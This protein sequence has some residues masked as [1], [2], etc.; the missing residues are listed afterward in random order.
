M[1]TLA[2][3]RANRKQQNFYNRLGPRHLAPL[4]EVLK[5]LVPREPKSKAVPFQWKYQ[6]LR[7]LLME[8]GELVSAEEAERRAL[9]LENPAFPG[10]SRTTSTMYAAVQLIMPG[11]TAPAHRHTASALRFML[12]G[13]GAFTVVGGERTT[14]HRGDFVITPAWAFHDHGNSGSEP[15][16]WMDGLDIHIVSFF[17]AMF[18]EENNDQCQTVSRPEG[19]ALARFG[20][21]LLPIDGE[22]R[23]GLTTPIF[24]YPFERTRQALLT[25]AQGQDPDRHWAFTMR[26]ANPLDGGWTMPTISAWMMYV[27]RGFETARMRSTDGIVMA[28]ADGQGTLNAVDHQFTFSARD[29][30]AIPSWTWRSLKA[31][32]DC[33]L[34]F[35]SDRVAQEKLGLYREERQ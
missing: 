29:I 13:E 14:M 21:G 27:P 26:Y 5:G 28:V 6:E 10:Q 30:H 22:S 15:C 2:T 16:A 18:S 24:N 20:E 34:F 23:Y 1:T 19:D 8:S 32:E 33:F 3:T 17:E 12:E 7:P 9:V 11:E 4:W 35:F 31:S 25:A